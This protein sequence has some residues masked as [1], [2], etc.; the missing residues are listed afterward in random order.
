MLPY[1]ITQIRLRR[2][3]SILV[4][5]Y[6][7]D[8]LKET[9]TLLIKDR[10]LFPECENKILSMRIRTRKSDVPGYIAALLAVTDSPLQ[11]AF[12]TAEPAVPD[13]LPP[14]LQ[15]HIIKNYGVVATV[16]ADNVLFGNR[17][18]LIS[19]NVTPW[20]A[21]KEAVLTAAQVHLMYLVI[22]G[23]IAATMAV[24]YGED[25]EMKKATENL[26]ADYQILVDTRDCNIN[27]S[28]IRRRY[29][30]PRAKIS[31][32]DPDELESV[33]E[34]RE[35]LEEDAKPPVML[36][37]K[38]P[39]AVLDSICR[40]RRL[41]KSVEISLLTQRLGI[42]FGLLLTAVAFVV[43]PAEVSWGWLMA[44]QLL[45]TVPTVA[46]SFFSVSQ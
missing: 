7:L 3:G 26:S 8:G 40:T 2:E 11:E 41:E 37:T 12:R 10:D 44:F 34:A 30:L 6:S 46:V 27:E 32:P 18:L 43:W 36:T 38:N 21:D 1:V 39:L 25:A 45:W 22:N 4:G 33:T 16:N 29:D 20:G 24:R 23:E 28:M 9:D 19:H 15:W 14:V 5:N 31:L 35:E 13:R 42:L 17:N